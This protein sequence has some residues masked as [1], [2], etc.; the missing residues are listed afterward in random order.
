MTRK[1]LIPDRTTTPA[2]ATRNYWESLHKE[3]DYASV[4]SLTED[5]H[6]RSKIVADI[7]QLM[8]QRILIPGCGT[9]TV[10]QEDLVQFFRDSVII[11]NDFPGVVDIAERK[12]N[13]PRVE[14]IGG[15]VR[16]LDL[17]SVDAVIHI[18]ST[19]SNSDLENRAILENS[20]RLLRGTGSLVGLFPTVFATL[21][22]AYTTRETWRTEA[23]D[24]SRSSYSEPKQMVEQIFYTPSRLR[25]VLRES[26]VNLERMEIFFN[27][28]DYL[29][30]QGAIHYGLE[31]DDAV[32]YHLYVVGGKC[33]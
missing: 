18:T 26:G 28:S 14:Y 8:P 2:Q 25:V 24:L 9:R 11:C 13:H 31:D 17:P 33:E 29:K 5:A 32:L 3:T 15:D 7:E 23:L 19:V 6:L 12:F 16:D 4:Y 21:D 30:Q 22:I 27:D 10:L 20:V 1:W